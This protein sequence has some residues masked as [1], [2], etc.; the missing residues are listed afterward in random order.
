MGIYDLIISRRTIRRFKQGPISE[1]LLKQMINAARLAPSGENLQ[2]LEYIVINQQDLLELVFDTTR[3]AGYL[4]PNGTPKS[5]ERPVAYIVVLINRKTK[6]T[7]GQ[8][9]C[10]ASIMCMIL[11]ALEKEVG[12]CWIRS[13]DREK[14]KKVLM[15]PDHLEIDSILALGYPAEK[16]IEVELDDT[17]KYWKDGEGVLHVPKRAI[18]DIT[19]WNRY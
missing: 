9:D 18:E 14:L 15:V 13:I 11:T 5:G 7:D 8:H 16:P 3:W 17:V 1:E 6:P 10:G 2:P 12:T 4:A 19:H